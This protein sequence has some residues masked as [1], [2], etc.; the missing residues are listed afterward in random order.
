MLLEVCAYTRSIESDTVVH[1]MS[2]C[3]LG[4]AVDFSVLFWQCQIHGQSYRNFPR[5]FYSN[6]FEL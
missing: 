5:S 3:V 6:I 1:V 4:V 2:E